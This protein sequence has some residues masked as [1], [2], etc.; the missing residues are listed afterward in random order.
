VKV[1]E[2]P[3]AARK[4]VEAIADFSIPSLLTLYAKERSIDKERL[5]RAY[6]HV[7]SL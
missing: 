4:Q 1:V 6:S 7:E 3:K 2:K 5:M